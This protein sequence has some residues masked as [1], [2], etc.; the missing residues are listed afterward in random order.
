MNQRGITV[1][2]AK[3]FTSSASYANKCADCISSC[4]RT[5]VHQSAILAMKSIRVNG[6]L[7]LVITGGEDNALSVSQIMYNRHSSK[8][9]SCSTLIITR[10]HACAITAIA[11]FQDCGSVNGKRS[12]Y[13]IATSGTDQRLKIWSITVDPTG[14][15]TDSI[16]VGVTK[17]VFTSVADVADLDII[18]DDADTAT[19]FV[20]GIGLDIWTFKNEPRK[21]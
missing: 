8:P 20:A 12:R 3:L 13:R 1:E 11:V 19:L 9:I 16:E 4:Y 10:A 5:K 17:N 7:A 15:N 18:E 6:H 21:T 14:Q 2:A